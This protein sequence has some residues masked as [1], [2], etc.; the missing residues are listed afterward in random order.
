[1]DSGPCVRLANRVRLV[2]FFITTFF[3]LPTTPIGAARAPSYRGG[4]RRQLIIT[5]AKNPADFHPNWP[6]PLEAYGIALGHGP[7][8]HQRWLAW[9]RISGHYFFTINNFPRHRPPRTPIAPQ[10]EQDMP[11][12]RWRAFL[13]SLGS[14]SDASEAVPVATPPNLK[15]AFG[16]ASPTSLTTIALHRRSAGPFAGIAWWRG[17]GLRRV[18]VFSDPQS[19]QDPS[20][21]RSV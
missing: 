13:Q 7:A 19:S 17:R 20:L 16:S 2:C 12:Y 6:W 10:S 9:A 11:A 21:G 15:L 14:N 8:I 18:S 3:S 5:A 1:V 4:Q